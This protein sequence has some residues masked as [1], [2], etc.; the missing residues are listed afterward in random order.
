[1][2]VGYADDR[3]GEIAVTKAHGSEH[4]AVRCT[5]KALG[6]GAATGVVGHGGNVWA[7]REEREDGR[8]GKSPALPVVSAFPLRTHRHSWRHR[9]LI[10][11]AGPDPMDL[12]HV[13]DED[14]SV[15]DLA[16]LGALK[17]GV[18]SDIDERLRDADLQ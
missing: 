17:D 15:P 5:L 2:G 1:M 6:D 18:H 7:G 8:S 13:E 10:A 11:L 3:L 14:L 4:G 9:C 12:S 16:C